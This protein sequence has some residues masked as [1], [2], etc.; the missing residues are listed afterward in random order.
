MEAESADAPSQDWSPL[1][2]QQVVDRV[3][4]LQAELE[5][6]EQDLRLCAEIGQMLMEKNDV[7]VVKV[8]GVR[9]EFLIFH[10]DCVEC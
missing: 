3:Y 4:L 7:L 8:C 1:Q 9:F 6:K 5:R 2:L 10:V